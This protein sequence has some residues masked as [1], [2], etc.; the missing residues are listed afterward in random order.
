M[1]LQES[2]FLFITSVSPKRFNDLHFWSISIIISYFL[3]QVFH[4]EGN[5]MEP[6]K[7]KIG[8][9]KLRFFPCPSIGYLGL[10]WL[11]IYAST[12]FVQTSLSTIKLLSSPNTTGKFRFFISLIIDSIFGCTFLCP[13]K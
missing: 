10:I 11:L 9:I 3:L 13:E 8:N 4:K 2:V 7:C 6:S 5:L 12:T 1:E